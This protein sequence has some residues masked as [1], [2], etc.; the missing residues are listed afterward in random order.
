MVYVETIKAA[1]RFVWGRTKGRR[2]REGGRRKK[3]HN[4]RGSLLT[5]VGTLN[6][7][8]FS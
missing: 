4:H 7:I 6:V 3:V 8:I 5:L 1:G 2:G